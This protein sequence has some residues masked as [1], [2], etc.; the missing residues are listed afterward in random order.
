MKFGQ[1]EDL[2]KADFSF[3]E[4]SLYTA[5]VLKKNKKGLQG[6]Y[7][8]CAKWNKTD[9]KGFYPRGTRD[10]LSYYAS[11]F[12]SIELN[13]TF[14]RIPSSA[15]VEAWKNKTPDKFK[16]FPKISNSISHY[17]RLI[18]I[19]DLVT[20]YIASIVHFEEKLGRCFLQLHDNFR[21]KDMQ[22]LEGFIQMWPK[23]IP[24]G[25]ELRNE[26][27]YSN[28]E[29]WNN[30]CTLFE[31]YSVCKII[32][33][34][35]GRRDILDMRLT[36]PDVF[37]RFVGANVVGD[38]KRLDDWIERVSAWKDM[39]LRNLYFF[40]HQ[41]VETNCPLLSS[42]FIKKI[43]EQWNTQLRIPKTGNLKDKL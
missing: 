13:A 12:N 4:D 20:E 38:Y 26:E 30:V 39:G 36:S 2:S 17:R 34:T 40:V 21:P 7:V 8:G 33:D 22:R 29:I 31:H 23:E 28:E 14:Y 37:V 9:L 27:W 6:V 11:Q 19:T 16:F 24:L 3:P 41:N 15:Q 1:V 32:V 43:N 25:V 18:N 5:E 42:Y 35:A 10:E